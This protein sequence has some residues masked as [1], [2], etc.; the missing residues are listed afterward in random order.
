ESSTDTAGGYNIGY[1][2][3]GEWL[4]YNVNVQKAGN[5]NLGFRVAYAS[6]GGKFHLAVDGTNLTGALT[7]PNTGG[8]QK[9][10]TITKTG[11]PLSAGIHVL[12]LA[13]DSAATTT[14]SI[15]NFNYITVSPTGT[16]PPPSTSITIQAEDF[17]AGVEGV[18]Y[19]DVDKANLGNVYRSTGVDI[20]AT[21]DTGGGYNIGWTKAGEW[22][23]YTFNVATAGAYTLDFRVASAGSNGKFHAEIDSK[24]V[25]GSLTVPNTGN[26]QSWT[27]VSK[28][29]VALTA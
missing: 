22:L 6:T 2:K 7:V 27:T 25:T 18:A 13:M 19:H 20:Q 5:Y 9:W 17:N 23:D 21:T 14:G 16:T 26:F 12:R 1:A 8:N 10:T 3:P 29:G 4:E 15:G 24:N 11:L 28:S